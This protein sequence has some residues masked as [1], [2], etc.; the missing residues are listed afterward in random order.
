MY[1]PRKVKVED[2]LF[3]KNIYNKMEK[4]IDDSDL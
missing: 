4:K 1:I 2:F 3:K